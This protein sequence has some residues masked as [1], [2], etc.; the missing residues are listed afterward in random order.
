GM[1]CLAGAEGHLVLADVREL[2]VERG[3]A[4]VGLPERGARC[5]DI[6]RVFSSLPGQCPRL[7]TILF[8]WSPSDW[9]RFVVSVTAV[10]RWLMRDWSSIIESSDVELS[11]DAA[12]VSA[13]T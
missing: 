9:T 1:R 6:H 12:S 3:H 7:S 8:V 13:C 10:C 2:A 5:R 11:D 4:V